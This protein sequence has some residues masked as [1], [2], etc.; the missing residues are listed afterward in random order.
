NPTSLSSKI[1]QIQ[2]LQNQLYQQP[3]RTTR[4]NSNDFLVWSSCKYDER[5]KRIRAI[6]ILRL[7]LDYPLFQ[8]HLLSLLSFRNLEGQTPFM[9]AVNCCAYNCALILFEY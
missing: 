9:S 1:Q 7:L 4:S 2:Y 6:K 3:A 8:E 5:E